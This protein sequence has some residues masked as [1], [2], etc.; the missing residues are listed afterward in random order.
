MIRISYP[1]QI[2]GSCSVSLVSQVEINEA[3][4]LA[5]ARVR[6]YM[7]IGWSQFS[8]DDLASAAYLG[9]AEAARRYL[10]EAGTVKDT[11]FTSHA[12]PWINKY[13]REYITNNKTIV[14][15]GL[16]AL[17]NNEAGFTISVDAFDDR[18]Y[19][20]AGSDHKGWLADDANNALEHI[21]HDERQVS[22][23][24][25]VREMCH[26]LSELERTA[27]FL[28]F[29]IDTVGGIANDI[30]KVAKLL[31]IT[32]DY[33][34]EILANAFSK[35]STVSNKYSKEFSELYA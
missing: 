31:D 7:S 8:F 9:I 15:A 21:E 28:R 32:I 14:S 11:K 13:I 24:C 6:Y 17:Y 30:N 34:N 29:G 20:N 3:M 27:I 1:Y 5:R 4:S 23:K 26:D 2:A 12:Y 33:A 35:L 16:G 22:I 25:I 10:P 19:D 18:N